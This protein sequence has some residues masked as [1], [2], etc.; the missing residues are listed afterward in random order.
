MSVRT[1]LNTL[2]VMTEDTYLSKEGEAV[3]VKQG[4]AKPLRVPIHM[5]SAIVFLAPAKLSPY[6]MAL[7][8]ERNVSVSFLESNGRF[9][10]RVEGRMSGNVLLRKSQFRAAE[11]LDKALA[12]ARSF[13][14]GKIHNCRMVLGRAVRDHGDEAGV[15]QTSAEHLSRCLK[16]AGV[17]PDVDTL[18]GIEGEAARHYFAAFPSLVRTTDPALK[19]DGRT[20][21]P[22]K[23][24][25]N[26][27]LSFAYTMLAL[28]TR[29]A[30]ETVGLDPQVGYLHA[31]RPGRVSL[32]LDL[33][34]EFRP[35]IA[36]RVVLSL[37]NRQQITADG[38]ESDEGG[39]VRL[40]DDARKTFIVEYQKRK[41]EE[42]KHP[43]LGEQVTLGLAP[44]LQA[45]LLARALR[46][47][48][49]G[50]PPFLWK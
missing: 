32:A 25:V 22:P 49:D 30:C 48:M 24:P 44:L 33:A 45:R 28:D 6:L 21:R 26:A 13:V 14:Q 5:L 11:A 16:R 1:H 37:L 15:V 36:E 43:F 39:A 4:D 42:I 17:A 7:C 29:A 34:E 27:L 23:D 40:K 46:G 47:D 18:R 19:M 31:D 9:L 50:Y 2:F 10:A 41:K 3:V 12:Y 38:F 8:A 20:R 35:V